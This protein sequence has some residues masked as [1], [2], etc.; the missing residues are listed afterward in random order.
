M[1][2]AAMSR[3]QSYASASATFERVYDEPLDTVVDEH[4][5]GALVP[6]TC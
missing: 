3:A 2:V 6:Y 4:E 1:E 5:A